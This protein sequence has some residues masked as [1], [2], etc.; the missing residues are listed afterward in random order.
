MLPDC[1]DA[2]PGI[3]QI[4]SGRTHRPQDCAGTPPDPPN[5]AVAT[6]GHWRLPANSCWIMTSLLGHF[7]CPGSQLTAEPDVVGR[8]G[9]GGPG[10]W[11]ALAER[12]GDRGVA[13]QRGRQVVVGIPVDCADGRVGHDRG[14]PGWNLRGHAP[15]PRVVGGQRRGGT[16]NVVPYVVPD[17]GAG[18]WSRRSAG[19]WSYG[20]QAPFTA[21]VVQ[22]EDEDG[23]EL[24]L[25][26]GD[27]SGGDGLG[28]EVA[29]L[30]PTASMATSASAA[31]FR[32]VTTDRVV[33]TLRCHLPGGRKVTLP[34]RRGCIRAKSLWILYVGGLTPRQ[35]GSGGTS[36]RI[37]LACELTSVGSGAAGGGDS[38][39]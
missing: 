3:C 34:R 31:T 10:R 22:A 18:W 32:E 27:G 19:S 16:G 36:E 21:L 2:R 38:K 14:V 20:P 24:E 7:D 35:T 11:H 1:S 5:V 33:I 4:S 26:L 30:H 13:G 39:M 8:P 12:G 28:V 6:C 29:A 17:V 9:V 37:S 15:L 25:E 23:A